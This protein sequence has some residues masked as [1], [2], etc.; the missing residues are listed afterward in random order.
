MGWGRTGQGLTKRA[1]PGFELRV[2]VPRVWARGPRQLRKWHLTWA[3]LSQSST[4]RR[5]WLC[6]KE[7]VLIVHQVLVNAGSREGACQ[8]PVQPATPPPVP[9]GHV[10]A[11]LVATGLEHGRDGAG[12]AD[13][14]GSSSLV[15]C[16]EQS[17]GWAESDTQTS[18]CARHSCADMY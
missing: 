11:G 13:G 15:G 2:E 8:W 4:R 1:Q 5:W 7:A 12:V 3:A 16:R 10:L 6:K 17:A 18:G 14:A 9:G